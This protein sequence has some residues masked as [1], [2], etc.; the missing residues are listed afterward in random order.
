[1]HIIVL[2]CKWQIIAIIIINDKNILFS[3]RLQCPGVAGSALSA[4]L[5]DVMGTGTLQALLSGHHGTGGDIQSTLLLYL[6]ITHFIWTNIYHGE[7]DDWPFQIN[8][9]ILSNCC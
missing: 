8:K 5:R 4:G 1:M 9:N 3:P 6:I 7:Y 2:S